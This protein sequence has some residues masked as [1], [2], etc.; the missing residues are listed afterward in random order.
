MSKIHEGK[1]W[2][3]GSTITK[4]GVNF[5]IAAPT[6]SSL[7][8]LLFASE[9]ESSPEH[10]FKLS[11]K[12]R[13][14][15]YWH[16]EIEGLNAGC[17]YGYRVFKEGEAQSNL[18]QSNKV[19]L[20]PCARAICGWET[21]QRDK[22]T[23]ASPN[24]H[25]C[26][27]GVVC[28]RDHFD[29]ESHP[30]PKHLWSRSIIYELHLGGFTKNPDSNV[31]F[32]CKGTFIGLIEK[33]PYLRDLGVTTIELL[34]VFSFDPSDAPEGVQ[35]YWGYSPINWF[36]PHQNYIVGNDPL[37]ARNQV[38]NLVAACHDQ[39][40]EVVI[41]VVY[42]HTTEGNKDGP[43]ISWRGFDESLYYYQNKKG[44]Y[45]DVSG[46]GNSIAANRPLVR[47]LIIESMR[48]W[49]IELGVDGFRFDL[50]IALSRGE[51]LAPLNSPPL[52]E[53]IESDPTLSDL[54]LISEPWDCGGLYRL[55]DFPAT[56][57]S[58]WNGHFRDDLRKFWKGEKNSVWSLKDRLRGSKELYK[59]QNA[60]NRS[61]NFITAHDGFTLH[62]LVSYSVKHNLANGE[63][64]RDG[65]NHNNSWNNNVEGPTSDIEITSLR[66]RQKLNLISSLL[67]SPGIPMLSMGDEVG[68]SQ[69]GN[70]NSW[71]QNNQLGW[72]I[73][74]P[75][76]CDLDLHAYVKK[77][78]IV[79]KLLPQ[80]FSPENLPNDAEENCKSNSDNFWVQWHGI[81]V[82]QPDWGHWSHTI[83]YSINQ[84]KQGA[85]LWMGLN[86]YSK[87]MSFELP[88]PICSWERLLDTAS[89]SPNDLISPVKQP[90]QQII[91]LA[92]KS[93]VV[94]LDSK[95]ASTIKL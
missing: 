16:I 37:K 83:S 31:D 52:F 6:A 87:K 35:N 54:K 9:N 5:C 34:P 72:M 4:R 81:K 62:D 26:L 43:V 13:S 53:E 19:L 61:I 64:N 50:G 79:R 93:L 80:L 30:R 36:T 74:H 49:A 7:E 28:E 25:S 89:K 12:N 32:S 10:V 57:I 84:G 82:N 75:N 20:D 65:E 45:L 44:E 91:G 94:L 27:K 71:C 88:T 2:P 67:L 41:D 85:V 77:L 42:N 55:S 48:C 90:N 17:C 63:N 60:Q 14:G 8:L 56:R 11:N 38:R 95:Y 73:W 66:R 22:A 24:F 86:S 1:P 23:G 59:A 58:T 3:L 21:Y 40:L 47:Q 46:C 69:G 18:S 70:N 15:D 39:G 29:F 78:L 76:Q 92:R 33:I 51:D 68:R